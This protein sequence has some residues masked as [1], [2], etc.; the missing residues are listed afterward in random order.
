ML[1]K[2]SLA[3]NVYR[4]VGHF[5]QINFDNDHAGLEFEDISDEDAATLGN[6][7]AQVSG[8]SRSIR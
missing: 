5:T 1:E 8:C 7:F 2:T 3:D 4:R 6:S